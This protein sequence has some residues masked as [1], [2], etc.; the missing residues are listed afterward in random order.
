VPGLRKESGGQLATADAR[1]GRSDPMLELTG[2]K[3]VEKIQIAIKDLLARGG[4]DFVYRIVVRDQ[5]QPDFSLSLATDKMNLPAG[6]TQ[7]IPVQISRSNYSGP[8]EVSIEAKSFEVTLQ[9]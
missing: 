9:G 3:G 7:V 1:P 5:A 6:G 4:K 8:I 2:P